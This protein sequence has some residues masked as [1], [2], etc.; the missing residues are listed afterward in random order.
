MSKLPVHP[1]LRHPRTGAP[2]QA[3][4][5]V[6]G[7]AIWPILGGDGNDPATRITELHGRLGE[8]TADELAELR[9]LVQGQI[10]AAEAADL[11]TETLEQL[12]QLADIAVASQ[13]EQTRRDEAA[14]ALQTQRDEA[15]ARAR[16][17][18][19]NIETPAQGEQQTPADSGEQ[20][21]ETP[22]E[23]VE[24]QLE[25][26]AASA[27]PAPRPLRTFTAPAPAPTQTRPADAPAADGRVRA[28][29]T[30][31]GRRLDEEHEDEQLRTLAE[32][33]QAGFDA[34]RRSG[35]DHFIVA[36]AR[37][38]NGNGGITQGMSHEAA[39]AQMDAAYRASLT[40]GGGI[41]RPVTVDYNIPTWINTEEPV[42]AA[43]PSVDAPRGGLQYA[44][45]V[46]YDATVYGPGVSIWTEANDRNP[47]GPNTGPG[48][49]GTGP[50]SKPCI[51]I[52]CSAF[53]EVDV[54][55]ITQCLTVGN[56]RARFSPENVQMAM[57][58]LNQAFAAKA[59]AERLRQMRSFAK[60]VV[61]GSQQFGAA[62][63]ILTKI[64]VINAYFRSVYR[65]SASVQLR[66]VWQS[67][68]REVI[69]I[70][71]TKAAFPYEGDQ[72][73]SLS[74]SNA[75]IDSWLADRNLVP[76]WAL[77]DDTTDQTFAKASAGSTGSPATFPVFPNLGTTG[78]VGIRALV[79]PEGTYQRLDGGQLD[80]GVVR[81]SS[82]NAVNKY[83]VFSEIFEA[84]APRGF[85][86]LDV[87]FDVIPNG[88]S[89][90]T[91]TPA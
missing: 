66:V 61:I 52:D 54:E 62:R 51:E 87:K 2:L 28:S 79:Y 75:Q 83:Q 42:K 74:V 8:L 4:G 43:L 45:A 18:L 13:E 39:R 67:W 33:F 41:C 58:Y 1:T 27:R 89:A 7:R 35:Q 20:T 88:A 60:H 72:G 16:G 44:Q 55:A 25:P 11:T 81:D 57:G 5:V 69:R 49:S 40:A 23:Q 82:L 80:L 84:V 32:R 3:V 91:A 46:P 68:V 56:M 63:D 12:G 26:V 78:H 19:P 22:A 6:A 37:W 9:T 59:E 90:G 70:D 53:T 86:S 64:D 50:A 30:A 38:S 34:M 29:L 65:L 36:S 14:Q 31:A 24:Q 21:A 85:E 48:G 17:A 77:D 76:V 73:N 10:D 47:A 71:L 15:L